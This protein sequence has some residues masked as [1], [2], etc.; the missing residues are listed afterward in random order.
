MKG[1][2][3]LVLIYNHENGEKEELGRILTNRSLTIE[4]VC[5]LLS[6]DLTEEN[7]GDP[8]WYYGNFDFEF[9]EAYK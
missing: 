7:N 1:I 9:A 5:N 8:K 4:E 6:I 2:T 3:M